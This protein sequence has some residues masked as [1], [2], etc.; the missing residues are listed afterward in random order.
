MRYAVAR[1]RHMRHPIMSDN[2]ESTPTQLEDFYAVYCPR[3]FPTAKTKR[4][5]QNIQRKYKIP[6]A[7]VG[8]TTLV[9][10]RMADDRLRDLAAA[11]YPQPDPTKRGRGRPPAKLSIALF[12]IL[13]LPGVATSAAS[14]TVLSPCGGLGKGIAVA[15]GRPRPASIAAS[16]TGRKSL[17]PI[18]PG[19][20]WPDLQQGG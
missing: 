9:D 6:V 11:M 1:S 15:H 10:P 4:A 12:L 18:A 16:A 19:S 14:P 13:N 2:N 17:T 3:R 8:N 20:P 7:R 5:K